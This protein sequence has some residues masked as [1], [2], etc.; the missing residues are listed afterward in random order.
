MSGADFTKLGSVLSDRRARTPAVPSSHDARPTRIALPAV[1]AAS[2]APAPLW[3]PGGSVARISNRRSFMSV[4]ADNLV[5]LYG[6]MRPASA[7][8]IAH[9]PDVHAGVVDGHPDVDGARLD[10]RCGDGRGGIDR[11]DF[12]RERPRSLRDSREPAASAR[13]ATR[14]RASVLDIVPS[15]IH[16]RTPTH[17]ATPGVVPRIRQPPPLSR[18]T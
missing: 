13:P 15:T 6:D 10:L 1:P 14:V 9:V 5:R 8:P 16:R 3:R 11:G 7:F 18:A 2:R 4:E 12:E 17:Y